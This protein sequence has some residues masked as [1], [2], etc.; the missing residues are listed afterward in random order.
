MNWESVFRLV[1]GPAEK[2]N[3]I[4]HDHIATDCPAVAITRRRPFMDQDFGYLRSSE[5][6]ASVM[7]ARSH[8]IDRRIDPDAVQAAQMSVEGHA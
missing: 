3:V 5:D 4:G 1:L 7:R 2:M 6:C 8:K